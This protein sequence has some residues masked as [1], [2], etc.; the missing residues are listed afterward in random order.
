MDDDREGRLGGVRILLVDDSPDVLETL[1]ML[2][3][4]EGAWV[5]TANSG[6]QA[7]ELLP[8][9]PFDLLIS[10][11][12][13][14]GMDGHQL[15]EAVRKRLDDPPPGIALTGFASQEDIKRAI[16]AGFAR[17]LGKPVSFDALIE[18]AEAVVRGPA[19]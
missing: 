6:L 15:I 4:I 16:T 9:G 18:A 17:H 1:Q 2:L 13:M 8:Q 11:I 7:L 14:P 5:I 3:E 19:G 10:D 12:G